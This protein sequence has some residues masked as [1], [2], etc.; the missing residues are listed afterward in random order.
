[1]GIAKMGKAAGALKSIGALALAGALVAACSS[2]GGS[3]S[4]STTS[5]G[6]GSSTKIDNKLALDYTGGTAGKAT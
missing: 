4:S 3:S 2:G 5:G 6:G 1:M